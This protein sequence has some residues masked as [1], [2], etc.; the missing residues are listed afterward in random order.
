MNR[1]LGE[2]GDEDDMKSSSV[3]SFGL[4]SDPAL[5]ASFALSNPDSSF[6]EV[7]LK[8]SSSLIIE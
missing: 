3:I 8:V 2:D 5:E 7:F 1:T 6:G 4:P